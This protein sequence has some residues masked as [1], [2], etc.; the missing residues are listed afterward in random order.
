MG[1]TEALKAGATVSV[2]FRTRKQLKAVA[3]A[4]APELKH[5]ASA[6]ARARIV[7]RGRTLSVQFQTQDSTALRAIMNSYLRM[8]VA[9]MK[10]STTLMQ[11]ERLARIKKNDEM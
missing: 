3:D 7:L 11:I 10:V 9:T 8:L 4:L 5:P 6:K 1:K 2:L